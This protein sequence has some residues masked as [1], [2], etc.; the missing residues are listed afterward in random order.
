MKSKKLIYGTVAA[1]GISVAASMTSLLVLYNHISE[2]TPNGNI[3]ASPTDTKIPQDVSIIKSRAIEKLKKMQGD[4]VINKDDHTMASRP[5]EDNIDGQSESKPMEMEGKERSVD[6]ARIDLSQLQSGRSHVIY[7]GSRIRKIG[8]T[9]DGSRESPLEKR[10]SISS[11]V[12]KLLSTS[13][14][15]TF[16]YPAHG[17][18]KASVIVFSDPTCPYCKNLH[19]EL[20]VLQDNGVSFHY[21]MFP[22]ALSRGEGDPQAAAILSALE[23]AWCSRNP[24]SALDEVYKNGIRG[25]AATSCDAPKEQG[26]VNFPY[27]EHYLM[28]Q[29]ADISATPTM[30]TSD[31]RVIKGFSGARRLLDEIL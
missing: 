19:D 16:N 26:R 28:T 20:P 6:L 18:E 27:A 17:E 25:Y 8:F 5:K 12:N 1:C 31:G 24:E 2:S 14:S 23:Y 22:R 15:F 30:L 29:I 3:Q 21:I 10:Q 4:S 11:F 9:Q 7:Q 13:E